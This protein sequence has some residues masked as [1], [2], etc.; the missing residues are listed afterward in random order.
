MAVTYHIDTDER[1]VYLTTARDSSFVEWRE[2]MMAV[3]SDP[4]YRPGFNFLSDRR[5]ETDV[6]STEFARS[7]AEFLKLNSAKMGGFKWAAVSGDM[8]IYGM[9]RMF[10][11]YSEIKG[12]EARAFT[13]YEEALEWVR[14]HPTHSE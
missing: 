8:A 1:V 3:L 6:P 5:Q 7:A 2:V 11:I 10:S 4:S 13:N 9:Q 12:I 14:E